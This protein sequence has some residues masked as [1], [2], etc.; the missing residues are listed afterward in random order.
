[1]LALVVVVL[2]AGLMAY[3]LTRQESAPQAQSSGTVEPPSGTGSPP[4]PPSASATADPVRDQPAA[5]APLGPS[6][7]THISIPAIGVDS[8]VNGI[9]LN[10]DGSLAVP[11]PGP[12]LNQAA[13]FEKSPTPGQPGPSVIE[14][15]VDS[16]SGPS[17]FFE[18]GSIKPGQRILVTR[19]D[20]TRL[21]FI[22]DGVRNYLKS[23]FPTRAVYG[24]MDL[25]QPALR[26]ITCSQFDEAT[27]HH[28]G[29]AVVFAHLS[30]VSG[31]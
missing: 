25:S 26:L 13:W 30:K 15:H 23:R 24:A 1:M 29:N 4:A 21:T 6:K 16:E 5:P 12:R 19:A 31:R 2:G 11:Q 22:V 18:L 20:G 9:G 8:V 3:S 28:I 27:R 14:G 7:P 10:G 17:V